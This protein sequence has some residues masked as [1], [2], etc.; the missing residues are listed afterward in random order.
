M[1]RFR[2]E[3]DR[4][5][6]DANDADA[7]APSRALRLPGWSYPFAAA[8]MLLIAWV[9]YWGFTSAG[10]GHRLP[11]EPELVERYPTELGGSQ[12]EFL[13]REANPEADIPALAVQEG[14][15]DL[16]AISAGSYDVSS[17][18]RSDQE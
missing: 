13:P 6:D 18:F 9:A 7:R 10:P 17:M 16:L 2:L 5:A 12:A 8:A 4:Q 11:R 1:V 14:D 15:R 3:R